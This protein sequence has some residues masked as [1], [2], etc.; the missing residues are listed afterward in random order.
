MKTDKK[1]VA[2]LA[3]CPDRKKKMTAKTFKYNH[4]HNCPAKRF[5]STTTEPAIDQPSEPAIEQPSE[6]DILYKSEPKQIT[7]REFRAMK[8]RSMIDSLMSQAF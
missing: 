7:D 6:P 5:T 8:R 4:V 1:Q 2:E 3:E